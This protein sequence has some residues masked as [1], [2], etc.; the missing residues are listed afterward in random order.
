[1]KINKLLATT[2][3]ALTMATAAHAGP[4]DG[5]GSVAL[6]GLS[7]TPGSIG[8]GTTFTAATALW[9]GGSTDLAPIPVGTGMSLSSI[10]ATVGS[11]VTWA[12]D[13]GGSWGSFTGTVNNVSASGPVTSRVVDLYILGTFTPGALLLA[14]DPTH[15]AGPM[16]LTFS[17]TQTGGADATPGASF[18]LASPPAPPPGV[19]EPMSMALFGLGL[20]GLGVAMRRKA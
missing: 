17:A 20:A 6:L 4:I 2:A 8:F 19:P 10:T 1:M 18:T 13:A 9:G 5:T 16:S 3:L 7:A 12:V 15:L 11:A 14:Q